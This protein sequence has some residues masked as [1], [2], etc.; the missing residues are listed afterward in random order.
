[1]GELTLRAFVEVALDR[2]EGKRVWKIEE[3]IED[4]VKSAV[5]P[6]CSVIEYLR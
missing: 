3:M 4:M 5:G 1:M 2:S 6:K